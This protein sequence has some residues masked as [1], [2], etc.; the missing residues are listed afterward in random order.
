MSDSV[1]GTVDARD[2]LAAIDAMPAEVLRVL[3]PVA[4][5]TAGR[6]V[7]AQRARVAVR[8]GH[9]R[10]MIRAE[11]D[12]TGTGVIVIANDPATREHVDLYL[13]WGTKYSAARPFFYAAADLEAGRHDRDARDAVQDLLQAKG[14]GD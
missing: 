8:S 10:D 1:T 9:T 7:A 14:L 5:A 4:W 6:I 13:E 11:A 12:F 3:E 2:L